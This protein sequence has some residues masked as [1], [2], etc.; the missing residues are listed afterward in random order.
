MIRPG[1]AMSRAVGPNRMPI[2]RYRVNH[3]CYFLP[4]SQAMNTTTAAT[5]GM[6]TNMKIPSICYAPIRMPFS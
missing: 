4:S 3:I 2:I 5:Q 1:V 6:M